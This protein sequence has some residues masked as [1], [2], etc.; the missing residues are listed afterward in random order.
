MA[1]CGYC[2]YWQALCQAVAAVK[3]VEEITWPV[4]D[5][6]IPDSVSD[7][8]M[9]TAPIVVIEGNWVLLDEPAGT[10]TGAS[11]N[12]SPGLGSSADVDFNLQLSIGLVELLQITCFFRYWKPGSKKTITHEAGHGF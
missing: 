11:Q 2:C 7:A 12:I 9:V 3:N 8:M 10:L 4:N 5:R 6:T 1:L